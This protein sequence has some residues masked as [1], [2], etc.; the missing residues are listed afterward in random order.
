MTYA[1]RSMLFVETPIFTSLVTTLMDPD[2]Y[3]KLQTS[4]LLR[5]DQGPVIKDS[6]GIR[7]VRWGTEARGKSG[8]LRIIYYWDKTSESIYMLFAYPKS[9]KNDLTP[10]QVKTLRKVVQEAFK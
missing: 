9:R 5:P 4:L 8:G 1:G 3:R 2:E 6:G 10:K 7:K